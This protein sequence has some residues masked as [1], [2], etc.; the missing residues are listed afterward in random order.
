MLPKNSVWKYNASMK[1]AVLLDVCHFG[2]M[3]SHYFK[4]LFLF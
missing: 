2:K 1:Q 4:L 3:S